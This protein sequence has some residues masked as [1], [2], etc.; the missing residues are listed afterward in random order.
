[1]PIDRRCARTRQRERPPPS[2]RP[3]QWLVQFLSSGRLTSSPRFRHRTGRAPRLTDCRDQGRKPIRS[4]KNVPAPVDALTRTKKRQPVKFPRWALSTLAGTVKV[5]SLNS[6]WKRPVS[7]WEPSERPEIPAEGQSN[8]T[9]KIG[10]A[11][12]RERE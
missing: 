12:C 3:A 2:T 4:R 9:W 8:T 11:S 5:I 10:R 6:S 1:E 7:D